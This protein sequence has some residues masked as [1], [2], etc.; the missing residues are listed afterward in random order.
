MAE[1]LRFFVRIGLWVAG[2]AVV[3]WLVSYEPAGT[4]LL[5]VLA[6]AVAAFLA[7]VVA[8]V[9]G[10]AIGIGR[11]G[12]AGAVNRVV[13]FG[14]PAADEAPLESH[15]D[16]VPTASAWPIIMAA[17]AVLIGLGLIVGP[18]LTVP[19]VAL[20]VLAAIGWITQLDGVGREP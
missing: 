1:E 2:A 7:V 16:V 17:A 11:T 8:T 9:R 10:R 6:I 12:L 13:G 20:L 19:G 14:D 5:V 4:V 3:Y 15:P 18:W